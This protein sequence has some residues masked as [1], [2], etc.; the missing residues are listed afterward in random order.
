MAHALVRSM[1]GS[2]AHDSVW[3]WPREAISCVDQ[4]GERMVSQEGTGA[5]HRYLQRGL[6][7]GGLIAP[8]L[9]PWITVCW[10]AGSLV[11]TAA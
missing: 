10:A 8:F 7:R 1:T 11:V 5:G 3:A 4:V 6:Q 2:A 9:V